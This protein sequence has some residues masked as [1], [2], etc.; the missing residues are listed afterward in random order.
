MPRPWDVARLVPLRSSGDDRGSGGPRLFWPPPM[1]RAASCQS[2][3]RA[4]GRLHGSELRDLGAGPLAARR[5][6]LLW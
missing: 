3:R 5:G 1:E 2:P 4:K 6:S